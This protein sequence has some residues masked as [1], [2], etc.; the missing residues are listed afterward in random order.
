[1]RSQT[2]TTEQLT[3]ALSTVLSDVTGVCGFFPIHSANMVCCCF[4]FVVVVFGK[5]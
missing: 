4:F 3:L 5:F 1:M 2:D